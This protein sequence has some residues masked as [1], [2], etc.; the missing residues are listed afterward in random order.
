[1]QAYDT[2]MVNK[3]CLVTGANSGIGKVTALEL[4]RMGARVVMVCRNRAKG[5]EARRAIQ[6]RSGN[7]AVDLLIADLASQREVRRLAQAFTDRYDH[8][9]VLI[10]NAGG[11]FMSRRTS[12]DGI[13]MTFAVNYLA[14][15]LLTHLLLDSLKASAPAR[16]VNV[17]S[18]NHA[19]SAVDP[20]D[21]NMEHGKYQQ[22]RAYAQSK[23]AVVL[24]TYE[25][26]CRLETTGV[27]ANVLHPGVV[28][29]NFWSQPLPTYLRWLGGIARLFSISAAKG[30]RTTIYL[31]SSPEVA[32]VTG[33]YF[34]K[35]HEKPSSRLSYNRDL[36]TSLW[37]LSERMTGLSGA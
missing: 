5:E 28:A 8:L 23:L 25:L 9:H 29:T 33:K 35:C 30:A 11:I 31:A 14:P 4:A 10:N 7:Q 32:S 17:S 12:P 15:F 36:Q 27:T 2:A 18:D 37:E 13:E 26:A 19:M 20:T 34:E 6:Q 1:M 22:M 3:V 16:I 21:W 24:F